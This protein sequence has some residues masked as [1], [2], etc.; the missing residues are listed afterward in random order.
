MNRLARNRVGGDQ[1]F[2]RGN[3]CQLQS[4]DHVTNGVEMLLLGAHLRV[5]RDKAALHCGCG[6]LEADVGAVRHATGGNNEQ[7]GAQRRCG[8][9]AVDRLNA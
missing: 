8:A 3:V 6:A 1:T 4:A 7:V 9:R 2:V 5:H